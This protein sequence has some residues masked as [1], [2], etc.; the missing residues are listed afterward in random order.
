MTQSDAHVR[1]TRGVIAGP[2]IVLAVECWRTRATLSRKLRQTAE[3]E[4]ETDRQ[5]QRGVFDLSMRNRDNVVFLVNGVAVA[6]T[7]SRHIV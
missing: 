1:A 2:P 5:E 7:G 4:I 3:Q 6:M